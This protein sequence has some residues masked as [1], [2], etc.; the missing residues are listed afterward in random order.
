MKCIQSF[1]CFDL[2]YSILFFQTSR[3]KNIKTPTPA[4]TP[5]ARIAEALGIRPTKSWQL[6]PDMRGGNNTSSSVSIVNDRFR[7]SLP[8]LS[9]LGSNL[10]LDYNSE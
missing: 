5:K 7:S 3:P 2:I 6:T 10:E 4:L 1:L 9:L 8:Q